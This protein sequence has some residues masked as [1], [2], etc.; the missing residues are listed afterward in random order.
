MILVSLS[1]F[2]YLEPTEVPRHV[3]SKE[4]TSFF[5]Y[6]TLVMLGRKD[7][8]VSNESFF[9]YGS[10]FVNIHVTSCIGSNTNGT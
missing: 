1:V 6:F 2:P 8:S 4:T 10:S 3:S 9:K 5:F 7:L